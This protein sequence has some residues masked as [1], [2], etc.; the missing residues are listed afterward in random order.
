MYAP[1]SFL[2]KDDPE[3]RLTLWTHIARSQSDNDREL[4]R[5][6]GLAK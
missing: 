3:D 4:L 6:M 1:N 2:L 5:Y